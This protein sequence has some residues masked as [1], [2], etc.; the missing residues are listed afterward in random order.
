MHSILDRFKL[1]GRVALVTGAG[2]GLGQG[3]ALGLAEAGADI[4]CV[5]L[6][7]GDAV[8]TGW[9]VGRTGRRFLELE[10]DLSEPSQRAGLADGVVTAFGRLDILV[11]NA[12]FTGRYPPEDYPA[13]EWRKL[14]EVHLMA[15]FDLSQ[16]AALQMFPRG[17]GKI[18]NMASMLTFQ[19]G[20]HLSAYATAKHGIAGMTKSLA[21][22]WAGR[23]INVN[24]IA[25]GYF[26]TDFTTPLRNDP[27]RAQDVLSRIPCGRWGQPDDL[28]GLCVFLASDASD[29]MHG[30]IIPIDGG[31]LVR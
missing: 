27:D 30:S 24:A 5:S 20:H 21:A 1:D 19:G 18:I 14:L 2:R 25:P 12:G 31:W 28:A 22:S 26:E 6:K 9:L 7:S 29:Y 13:D 10:A 23:G 17:R 15:A 16:Q 3:I 4:A 11:N 8:E